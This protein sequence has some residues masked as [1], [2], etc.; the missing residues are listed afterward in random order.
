MSTSRWVVGT[1]AALVVVA[2][3]TVGRLAVADEPVPQDR[4]MIGRVTGDSSSVRD[5]VMDA[6]TVEDL[7]DVHGL[8]HGSAGR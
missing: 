7:Q 2:A 6:R 5:G 3:V 8:E 4:V 1:A